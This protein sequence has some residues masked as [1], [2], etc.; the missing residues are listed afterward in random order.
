MGKCLGPDPVSGI[1]LPDL[2]HWPVL[3][4]RFKIIVQPETM[5]QRVKLK[6]N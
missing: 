4:P 1:N 5:L 3:E 2:Q 6:I